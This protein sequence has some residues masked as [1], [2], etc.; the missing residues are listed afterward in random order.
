MKPPSFEYVRP[1]TVDEAV[2][3]LAR[4]SELD[5][6]DATRI[7]RHAFALHAAGRRREAGARLGDAARAWPP[8]EPFPHAGA[9]GVLLYDLGDREAARPWLERSAPPDGDLAD[10]KLRLARLEL[11]AGRDDA[12]RAAVELARSADPARVAALAGDPELG[13]LVDGG[14]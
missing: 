2:E 4:A 1:K 9:L 13:R 8:G 11:A 7:V 3:A 14:R 5:P 6:H 12:A 10:A